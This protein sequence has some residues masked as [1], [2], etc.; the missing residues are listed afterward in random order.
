MRK[1]QKGLVPFFLILL[2]AAAAKPSFAQEKN[3]SDEQKDID[4]VERLI[5]S[6]S[7]KFGNMAPPP[8]LEAPKKKIDKAEYGAVQSESFYTDLAV[9]QKN[10][11]PKADRVYLSG[12]FSLLPSDVFFRTFGLNLKTSFHFNETWGLELFGYA[13]NSQARE[14][15]KDI[16]TTQALSVKSLVSVKAFYGMNLYFNSIY[17]KTA[18]ANRK[19]VPFEIY[20]TIGF[21][22]VRTQ[23]SQEATSVQ[24]GVGDIFSLSR[25]STLRVDL[26]WAIY[27]AHNYLGEEQASNSLFLTLSYGQLFPEPTYR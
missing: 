22:K 1:N 23:D 15:V 5:E 11:M 25:S 16:E 19:I 26:T 17:G 20:Q 7:S 10:Y 6:N 27:N 8:I 18:F 12:G 13:F 2:I 14:E 3:E 24:F 21:G 4:F 9:I